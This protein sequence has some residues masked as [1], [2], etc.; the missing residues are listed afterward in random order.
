MTSFSVISMP[1]EISKLTS[2]ILLKYFSGKA[3]D[4]VL[5]DK[6]AIR[7][8]KDNISKDYG[9]VVD[10]VEVEPEYTRDMYEDEY[11][12]TYDTNVVGADDA[13][14]ADELTN[15]RLESLID[16]FTWVKAFRIIP[17]FRILRLTFNRKSASKSLIRQILMASLI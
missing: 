9:V 7:D 2:K 16:L 13:D 12:D 4:I 6:S 15:R 10:I 5:G 14:S 3:D 1:K 8:I 17:E 11:D